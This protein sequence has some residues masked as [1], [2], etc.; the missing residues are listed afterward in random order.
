MNISTKPKTGYILLCFY[1]KNVYIIVLGG[2]I[3]LKDR[4]RYLGISQK[5]LAEKLGITQGYMSK[6]ENLKCRNININTIRNISDEL[7]LDPVDVFLFFYSGYQ[8]KH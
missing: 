4:R 5:Y 2:R 7:I 8:D 6:L 1:G 3:M